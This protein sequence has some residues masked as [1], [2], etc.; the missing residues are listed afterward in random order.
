VLV[1]REEH[2]DSRRVRGTACRYVPVTLPGQADW[3]GRLVRA[4]VDSVG[5]DALH[6]RPDVP[7]A[8]PEYVPLP[9]LASER[10]ERSAGSDVCGTCSFNKE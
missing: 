10:S 8:S 3:L 2:D 7:S 9:V 6:A 4:R 1:E 5:D